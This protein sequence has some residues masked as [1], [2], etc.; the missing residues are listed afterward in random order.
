MTNRELFKAHLA[1]VG[2]ATVPDDLSFYAPDVTLRLVNAPEGHT[3]IREGAQ[4]VAAF[5]VR[6][7][8]FFRDFTVTEPIIH[9][10]PDGFVAEYHGDSICIDTGRPYN[11]DYIAVVGVE[12]GQIKWIREYYDAIRVLRAIGDLD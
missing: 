5:M 2:P 7:T 12:N 1:L 4:E 3:K 6:I 9:E 11:Q 10:T 8:Q